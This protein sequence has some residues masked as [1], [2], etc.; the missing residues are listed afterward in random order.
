MSKAPVKG[1]IPPPN[2]SG[3]PDAVAPKVTTSAKTV[4][5]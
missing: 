4:V 1:P 3:K 2:K 5:S